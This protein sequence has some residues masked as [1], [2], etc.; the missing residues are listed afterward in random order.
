MADEWT[1]VGSVLH[2]PYA[3]LNPKLGQMNRTAFGPLAGPTHNLMG[4]SGLHTGALVPGGGGAAPPTL[5]ASLEGAPA[6]APIAATPEPIPLGGTLKGE[7]P[8][9]APPAPTA[10]PL[11]EPPAIA[12]PPRFNGDPYA[13]SAPGAEFRISTRVPTSKDA[14]P[15]V[16]QRSDYTIDTD[17]MK[18]VPDS[19]AKNADVIRRQFPYA[20]DA[21]GSH[22]EVVQQLQDHME[23]NLQRLYD[24]AGTW[25]DNG[26]ARAATWYDGANTVAHNMAGEFNLPV[27]GVAGVMA[28]L[29]PQKDW[30]Q[31]ADLARRML[32]IRRDQA[33]QAL[34]PEMRDWVNN[35][36]IPNI[37]KRGTPDAQDEAQEVRDALKAMTGVPLGAI[38][39]PERKAWFIR[40]YDEAHNDK[41]YPALTPEGTQGPIVTNQD[42]VTPRKIAWG[43]YAE[44]GKALNAL[45]NP[46]VENISQQMGENHKVRSFYNNIVS[47]NS[48]NGD[49][50][51]DTHAIAAA[52]MRP[53]GA[54]AP[55]VGAGLTGAGASNSA[56]SGSKGLYPIYADAIRSVANRN[57]VLPRQMQSI[58]WE[59]VRSL[60]SPAQ[61]RDKNF[62]NDIDTLW[63]HGPH[64][65]MSP[66]EIRSAILERA[67]PSGRI[68]APLWN[69]PHSDEDAP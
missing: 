11:M 23:G 49:T 27:Q 24:E 6:K 68:A 54:S 57:G 22:D 56:I 9:I 3:D 5:G 50:T 43:S 17:V 69:R 18:T 30:F 64:A 13:P 28:G 8:P 32:T 34:T 20:V 7:A 37:L 38:N 19:Y 67:D 66:D 42:G 31:N 14:P 35:V 65:G 58:T 46:S 41:S 61:K 1:D 36:E 10:P 40:W 48:D 51:V 12:P 45:E 44:I 52:L 63:Q 53:V 62:V 15:D 47:P 39:D 33:S 29:S 2:D 21:N 55:E 59:A 26:R 60:F 25:P 4:E 16:H